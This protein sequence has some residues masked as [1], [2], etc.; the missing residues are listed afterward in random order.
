MPLADLRVTAIGLA[1]SI[2]LLGTA[3]SV[4]YNTFLDTS[5]PLL[6]SLPHPLHPSHYFANKANPLNVYFI[7]KAWGWTSLAF[8]ALFLTLPPTEGSVVVSR[9]KARSRMLKW[10]AET[11]VFIVFVGWFFGP[12]LLERLIAASGGECVVVLPSGY[13]MQLPVEMCYQSSTISPATHPSLF[14]ASLMVPEVETWK[15]RPRL[16]KGHDVSGEFY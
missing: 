10:V 16:R 2:V 4:Q 5:N 3:Y 8:A 14:A 1:S 12:A 7:K 13:V 15:A 9:S 11:A 6:T